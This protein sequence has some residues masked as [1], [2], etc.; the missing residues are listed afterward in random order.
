MLRNSSQVPELTSVASLITAMETIFP[1]TKYTEDY[2][3]NTIRVL[4]EKAEAMAADRPNSTVLTDFINKYAEH[5]YTKHRLFL[6]YGRDVSWESETDVLKKVAAKKHTWYSYWLRQSERLF[7]DKGYTR[8][9]LSADLIVYLRTANE[10][11]AKRE[12]VNA[13]TGHSK[14]RPPA[15]T[16]FALSLK[17]QFVPWRT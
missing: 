6:I 15:R 8:K 17:T 16:N 7:E 3:N 1:L 9:E 13:H 2:E 10:I 4:Q 11:M 5:E 14:R 12:L